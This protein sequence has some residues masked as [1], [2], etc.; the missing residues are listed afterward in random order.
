M[1]NNL[2]KYVKSGN[3]EEFPEDRLQ[4]TYHNHSP[5][6]ALPLACKPFVINTLYSCLQKYFRP[7]SLITSAA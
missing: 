2:R 3:K 6:V 7:Q 4:A 1:N 5:T